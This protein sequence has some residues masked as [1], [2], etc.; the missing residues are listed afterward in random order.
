MAMECEEDHEEDFDF[1]EIVEES[2]RE[3]LIGEIEEEWGNL[4]HN[5]SLISS[6]PDFEN[7]EEMERFWNVLS[8]C[9]YDEI[10]MLQEE[11][12]DK[13]GV[14]WKLYQY[15]RMG[16]TIAPDDIM[17]RACCNGFGGLNGDV[18][19]YEVET[20]DD[21]LAALRY[22]NKQV[23][24]FCK[25]IDGWWKEEKKWRKEMEEWDTE[26]AEHNEKT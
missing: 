3:S 12:Y 19:E 16:A 14:S 10:E 26:I 21:V 13:L 23:R 11:L 15:G 22:I 18:Y 17:A 4:H 6:W 5:A 1:R 8:E 9:A 24:G 7:D 20:L 2:V 25:D